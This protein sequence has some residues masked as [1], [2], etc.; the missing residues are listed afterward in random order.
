MTFD[1]GEVLSRAWQITWKNRVLWVIGIGFAF[2]SSMMF[3]FMFFP[4]L[5]PVLMQNSR[6]DLMPVFVVGFI[7]LLALFILVL[8]PTS[9]F[10]QISLTLGIIDAEQ[11]EKQV[12]LSELLKGSLSFFWRVL[13]ILF[14]FQ[15]GMGLLVFIIQVVF[16]FVSILTL[17]IGTICIMPLS[18]LMYPALYGGVIWMEQAMNGIIVDN[19]TMI[20]AAKQSWDLIRSNVLSVALMA[21]IIYFALGL[22][23]GIVI[24]PLMIPFFMMPLM[25]ANHQ[26]NWTILSISIFS[27]IL[28]IP[29]F[30]VITGFSAIFS[31]SAWVLTYLR[32]KH[33]PKL[34]PLLVGATS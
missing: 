2:F 7:I 30:T 33:S 16:I 11:D 24:M 26:T 23:I 32:L 19:M 22:V 29:L 3:L 27:I 31:K 14:L 5:I 1:F 8:Y 18:L 9:V 15:V 34:Q 21:L 4:F 12:T 10:A 20:D 25:F 13:G 17:G 28:F 6:T